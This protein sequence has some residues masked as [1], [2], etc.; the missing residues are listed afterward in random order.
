[1]VFGAM[2]V[3]ILSVILGLVGIGALPASGQERAITESGDTVVL[4]PDGT[5][6]ALEN[7]NPAS[8]FAHP[9]NPDT[10][11]EKP[12]EA[13]DYTSGSPKRYILWYNDETW[14]KIQPEQINKQADAALKMKDRPSYVSI[15]YERLQVPVNKLPKAHFNNIKRMANNAQQLSRGYRVVNS[16]TMATSK[17][18]ASRRSLTFIYRSYFHSNKHGSIQLHTFTAKRFYPE[19]KNRIHKLLNGLVIND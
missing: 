10:V 8:N 9:D 6:L 14:Q 1:M 5:W 12:D 19:L 16:D 13:A 7:Y 3:K 15:I 18:K 2:H 11:V 17:V 4:K